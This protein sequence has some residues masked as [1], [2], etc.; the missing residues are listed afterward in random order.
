MNKKHWITV[1]LDGS[2]P[3]DFVEDLVASSYD[4]VVS[5]LPARLRPA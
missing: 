2:L 5:S 3:D 4:L 1:T